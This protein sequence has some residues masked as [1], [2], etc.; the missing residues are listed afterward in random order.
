MPSRGG[1]ISEI[2]RGSLAEKLGLLPG[3]VITHI[4][5]TILRDIIDYKLLSDESEFQLSVRRNGSTK[6][7]KIRNPLRKPA[8]ISFESSLFDGLRRCGN[9]CIFCFV[10]QL[11]KGLRKSLYLKDDDYRLSFLYGN[12]I[13]LNNAGWE[14]VE[15]IIRCRLS[16]LYISLH[17]TNR[18]VRSLIMGNS[19][20]LIPQFL[21]AF[22]E[23]SISVHVQIVLCPGVNDGPELERSLDDLHDNFKCVR[24]VG[25]VP[26]GLT[27]FRKRLH[28]LK[29]FHTEGLRRVV[30]QIE[31]WRKKRLPPDGPNWVYLAD[32]F[33][34]GTG[35]PLPKSADYDDY[36]QIENGIGLARRLL[37]TLEK[38]LHSFDSSRVQ[39]KYLIATG[40]LGAVLLN[41]A[42]GPVL[43]KVSGRIEIVTIPNRFFGPT[44]TVAGLTA[45]RDI[46]E[47]L[48][49][50]EADRLYIPEVMLNSDRLFIDDVSL[51]ELEGRLR[52]PVTPIPF[53]GS[54]LIAHLVGT[55]CG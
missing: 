53:D 16:P 21:I 6:T 22:S 23:A 14:D 25:V 34:L 9:K 36:P 3:D 46:L 1:R 40:K 30:A 43:D 18:D 51:A 12:F 32:E 37:D 48:Q 55:R 38:D 35:L 29:P 20:S 52:M 4:D 24:S 19:S 31:A 33:F 39:G 26:V 27:R 8:G 44:V 28:P 2:E 17:S 15:R 41:K 42:L 49:Q 10:D 11:P 7:L 5:N 45:G 54:H 13:T 47:S 50:R